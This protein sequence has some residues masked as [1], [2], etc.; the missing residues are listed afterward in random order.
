MYRRSRRRWRRW[1][2]IELAYSFHTLFLRQLALQAFEALQLKWVDRVTTSPKDDDTCL[3]VCRLE[4]L[5]YVYWEG[6]PDATLESALS[7]TLLYWIYRNCRWQW[8]YHGYHRFH[9]RTGR[10]RRRRCTAHP[11]AF[12]MTWLQVLFHSISGTGTGNLG[13]VGSPGGSGGGNYADIRID[14]RFIGLHFLV[15][16]WKAEKEGVWEVPA[17]MALV[18]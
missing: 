11:P 12:V 13:Y 2:M 4:A 14:K 17:P 15:C 10:R 6:T 1:R 16:C 3:A 18:I 7:H 9:P 5:I 8:N